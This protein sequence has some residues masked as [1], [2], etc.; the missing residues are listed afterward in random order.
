MKFI[1]EVFKLALNSDMSN[2]VILNNM[3]LMGAYYS[4]LQYIPEYAWERF[5]F[6]YEVNITLPNSIDYITR[7][8]ILY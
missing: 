7:K 6:L 4:N 1:V 5:E 2:I 3:E 8:I